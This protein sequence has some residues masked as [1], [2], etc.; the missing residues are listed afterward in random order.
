MPV[1]PN[2]SGLQTADYTREINMVP[3]MWGR[4]QELN[5]FTTEGVTGRTIIIDKVDENL[6][7][8]EVREPGSPAPISN[9]EGRGSMAIIVPHIP[10]D[11]ALKPSDVQGRRMPGDLGPDTIERKRAKKLASM[12]KKHALTLEYFRMGALKGLILDGAGKT[13]MNLYTQFGVTQKVEDFAFGTATTKVDQRIN[14]VTRFI[15]ENTFSGGTSTGVHVLCSPEWFADLVSHAKIREAYQ[16]YS[17][18]QAPLQQD[19]RRRFQHQGVVFEEY[20]ASAVMTDGTTVAR[21]IAAGEAY[22]FPTGV[23]DMY[24]NFFGPADHFD[25]VNT[26]GDEVY[27]WEHDPGTGKVINF[28]SESNPLPIV[29]R[30]RAVVKLTKT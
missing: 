27:V 10:L 16:F 14:D 21:F 18:T 7:L 30:P 8:L 9:P 6:G 22:A 20:N 25:Y 19:V 13:V 3:N 15:E 23:D 11:D 17:S 2:T 29:K 1:G 24:V 12:R 4:L 5:L 26:E 28:M